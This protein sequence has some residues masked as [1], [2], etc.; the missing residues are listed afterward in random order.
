MT[1]SISGDPNDTPDVATENDDDGT[2]ATRLGALPELL[3]ALLGVG[4]AV[5]GARR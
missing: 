1:S 3:L 2:L 4:A 5:T